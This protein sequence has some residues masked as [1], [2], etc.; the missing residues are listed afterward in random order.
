ML[1]VSVMHR[2]AGAMRICLGASMMRYAMCAM[3]DGVQIQDGYAGRRK[4]S[5]YAQESDYVLYNGNNL[6]AM[7][8]DNNRAE[9]R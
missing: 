7:L 9:N 4:I 1:C 5:G 2:Q 3:R 6:V 8:R